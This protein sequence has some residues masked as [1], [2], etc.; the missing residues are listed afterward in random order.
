MKTC[1]LV[2]EIP[3][4]EGEHYNPIMNV[5]YMQ[6]A[7]KFLNQLNRYFQDENM[8]WKCVLDHSAC[9]YNDIFSSE[10]QAV[11]FAPEAKTRQWLYKKEIQAVSIPKYYLDF[12]EYNEA[13][14][15]KIAIFFMNLK[16]NVQ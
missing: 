1:C 16:N 7:K 2:W 5:I 11:I 3:V 10:H 15:D 6:K 12:A 8:D 4:I 13:K 14:L 9:T